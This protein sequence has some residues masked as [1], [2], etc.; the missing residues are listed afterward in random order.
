M[1]S[2]ED[3]L[4]WYSDEDVA[5]TLEAMQ[6]LIAFYHDKGIDILK[7]VFTLPKLANICLYKTVDAKLSS[8][9]WGDGDFLEYI[10]EVVDGPSIVFTQKAFVDETF[11]EKQ[12]FCAF[13]WLG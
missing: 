1:G 10:R 8:F 3:F 2:T 4:R 9:K 12:Q 11:F 6:K 13:L 5:P 7:L